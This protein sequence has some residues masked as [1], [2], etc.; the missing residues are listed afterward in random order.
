MI[1]KLPRYG[2]DAFVLDL[3]DGTPEEEK[4]P[5]RDSLPGAVSGLRERGLESRLFVRINEPRSVHVEADLGAALEAAIDGIVLPKLEAPSE[6][7]R[8]SARLARAEDRHGRRMSLIGLIE[9]AAGVLRVED[10]AR[11][12]GSYLEALAFGAEDFVTGMRGVRTREGLEVLYAR[13][14]VVLAA[15][16][17]GIG[18]IDQVWVGIRDERGFRRDAELGR[19]LGYD[20]K[21]CVVPRQVEIANEVFSPSEDE[22]AHSRRLIQAYETARSEGHGALAFE[23]RM[24]D[25]PVLERART[26]VEL[27]SRLGGDPNSEGKQGGK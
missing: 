1:A 25:E 11:A 5:A 4:A 8:M 14:R 19:Q 17:A 12:P 3:E 9:T 26:I 6:L 23:G 18:A 10:L 27:A 20:G 15:R 7:E 22:V 2:A 21:L 16:A 13:S 24:V